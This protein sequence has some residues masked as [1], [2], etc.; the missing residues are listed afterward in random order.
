MLLLAITVDLDPVLH[1]NALDVPYEHIERL[2]PS[3]IARLSPHQLHS[4]AHSHD[5]H[6][7]NILDP[8][9]DSDNVNGKEKLS[10]EFHNPRVCRGQ[11]S[12]DRERKRD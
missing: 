7:L 4:T 1:D 10:S 11:M 12:R 9:V 5:D 8:F 2:C 3:Q 6:L